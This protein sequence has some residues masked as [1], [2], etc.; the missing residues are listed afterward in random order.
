MQDDSK[1][2]RIKLRLE[3]LDVDTFA[4]LPQTPA[5][6]TVKGHASEAWECEW[7]YGWDCAT[8][9]GV[10]PTCDTCPYTCS[11]ACRSDAGYASCG[12]SCDATNCPGQAGCSEFPCQMM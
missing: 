6:G 2:R 3:S 5:R 11:P 7:S 12:G 4:T 10:Q 9:V 1:R 8:R